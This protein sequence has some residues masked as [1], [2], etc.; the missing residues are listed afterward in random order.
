LV[1]R[2]DAGLHRRLTLISAPAGFGKTTLLSEWIQRGTGRG[3]QVRPPIVWVSLDRD[4]ND[5]KRFW[6]YFTA[7]LETV[8]PNLGAEVVPMLES[9]KLPTNAIL[10]SLVN[11]ITK[12]IET[13][14]MILDDYGD[15]DSTK[16]QYC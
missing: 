4:D 5:P 1:D 7:A 6:T 11:E 3:S 14:V 9:P 12:G 16:V 10:T 8:W 13:A 15:G 2:L